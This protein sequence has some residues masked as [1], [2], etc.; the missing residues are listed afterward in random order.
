MSPIPLYLKTDD[1]MPRPVDAEFYW[2]TQDGPFLCRNHPFFASD[3]PA[4]RPVRALAAHEPRC[5][6]R[7]PKVRA[8]TLEFIVGFFDRVYELHGSEAVVLLLWDLDRQRYRL[9][10]P[11][12]EATVW[13]GWGARRSPVDVRYTVPPL[14]ARHLLV[15]DVHC[16]GN[17]QAFTS[18]TDAADERYR[19]G[20]HGV[21]GRIERE[22]PEFHL[23]LAIDGHRFALEPEQFFEGYGKRRRF[24]PRQWLDRVTVKVDGW[25]RS[26]LARGDAWDYS[27]WG[28]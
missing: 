12:Q 22:P 7:Y 4:R 24:V 25:A 15:G 19:D 8:S 28:G 3:V 18:S 21:V 5:V 6:V 26:S 17:L 16:H 14:P 2:L 27:G 23:E 13:Q 10:V 1:R 9:L 11:E 20:V